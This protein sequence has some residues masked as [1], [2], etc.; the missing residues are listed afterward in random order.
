MTTELLAIEDIPSKFDRRY[1]ATD[2]E[3]PA[4]KYAVNI[5][6]LTCACTDFSERRRDFPAGDVRRVCAHLYEK[7][8]QTK[9]ERRFDPLVQLFIRY[10]REMLTYRTVAAARGRFIIGFPFGPRH[11]RA[12]G[13]VDGKSMLATYNLGLYEWAEGETPLTRMQA[14]EVLERMRQAY[15]EAFARGGTA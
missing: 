5:A 13:I 9:A 15:P 2:R 4:V 10:G 6:R 14:A 8:Y 12:I 1:V 11:L 7:L 3:N